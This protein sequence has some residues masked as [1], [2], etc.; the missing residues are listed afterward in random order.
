M[1][2]VDVYLAYGGAPPGGFQSRVQEGFRQNPP[3]VGEREA[4]ADG[5]LEVAVVGGD[6]GVV[7]EPNRMRGRGHRRERDRR[8]KD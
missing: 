5:H 8:L 2:T 1:L 4:P 6:A 3:H 7:G